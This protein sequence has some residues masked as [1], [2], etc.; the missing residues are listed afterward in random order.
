MNKKLKIGFIVFILFILFIGFIAITSFKDFVNEERNKAFKLGQK[1]VLDTILYQ[2]STKGY[3]E[4]GIENNTI[5]L[6]V[7]G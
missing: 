2:L 3:V 6:G 1:V 5:K 7:V 4:F